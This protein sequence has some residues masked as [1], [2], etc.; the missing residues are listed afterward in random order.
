MSNGG[1]FRFRVSD[2]AAIRVSAANVF[3]ALELYECQYDA[4][5]V[6]DVLKD[7]ITRRKNWLPIRQKWPRS[8]I[9]LSWPT[10]SSSISHT[11]RVKGAAH[12]VKRAAKA[13]VGKTTGDSKLEAEGKAET[14]AG[15]V[16]NTIG[17]IKDSIRGK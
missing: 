17:G 12:Q 2:V 14:A 15:K 7:T 1:G 8:L 9:E 13:G 16:Q 3:T 6:V 4:G 10:Q 11:D 5:V